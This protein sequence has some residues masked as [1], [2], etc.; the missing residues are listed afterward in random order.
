MIIEYNK[1]IEVTEKQY[2]A[3]VYLFKGII[4]HRVVNDKYYIKVWLTKYSRQILNI[5][6]N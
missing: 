3:F 1:P 6:N 4:A 2:H 5:L